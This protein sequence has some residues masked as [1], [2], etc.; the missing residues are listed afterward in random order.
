MTHDELNAFETDLEQ[1]REWLRS[2]GPEFPPI[3]EINH[4]ADKIPTLINL[5]RREIE[6][7]ARVSTHA[8]GCHAWG[9][10]HYDCLMR[11]YEATRAA[12]TQAQEAIEEIAETLELVG[13][14]L[15]LSGPGD[16]KDRKA[17]ASD[18]FGICPAI[19]RARSVLEAIR[20]VLG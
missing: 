4:I 20:K 11:R 9:P 8:P 14:H 13:Q 6:R 10:R 16:G 5:T 2:P 17:D 18:D 12:L 7:E 19:R 3:E 15:G 1:F